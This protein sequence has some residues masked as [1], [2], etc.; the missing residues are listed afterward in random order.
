MLCRNDSATGYEVPVG[1][2]LV[3][4]SF[5]ALKTRFYSSLPLLCW[6]VCCQSKS[7]FMGNGSFLPLFL[8]YSLWHSP[9]SQLDVDIVFFICILN[10]WMHIFHQNWKIL[11]ENLSGYPQ[12]MFPCCFPCLW[13]SYWSYHVTFWLI[14]SD[15]FFCLPRFSLQICP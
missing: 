6:K 7:H 9:Y 1:S 15:L 2:R 14:F 5:S 4:F 11:S 10:L 12:S 13:T 3:F 8:R